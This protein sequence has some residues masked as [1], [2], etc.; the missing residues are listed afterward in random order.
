MLQ[1]FDC[2]VR[3]I[4]RHALQLH[5]KPSSSPLHMELCLRMLRKPV[6]DAGRFTR[7]WEQVHA[8]QG[9]CELS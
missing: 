6:V 5:S 1:I 7:L 9:A 4:S 8:L 2:L 3:D